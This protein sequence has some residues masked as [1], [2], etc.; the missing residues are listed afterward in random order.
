MFNF[1]MRTEGL[2]GFPEAIESLA[3]PL[4]RH[5]SRARRRGQ[6]GRAAYRDRAARQSDCRRFFRPRVVEDA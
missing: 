3:L 4:Q 6:T 2:A 5:A 1:V